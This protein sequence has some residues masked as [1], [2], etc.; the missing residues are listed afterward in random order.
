MI[1]INKL[2]TIG[3][4][5]FIA[6][7]ISQVKY[8]DILISR[9]AQLVS[10]KSM[11]PGII[12]EL[13]PMAEASWIYLTKSKNITITWSIHPNASAP[14]QEISDGNW[15][16]QLFKD[17]QEWSDSSMKV[18][19]YPKFIKHAT[20]FMYNDIY[21]PVFEWH[22]QHKNIAFISSVKIKKSRLRAQIHVELTEDHLEKISSDEAV[23]AIE[24]LLKSKDWISLYN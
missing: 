16:L 22:D 14:L 8:H 17:C 24:E 5:V 18:N 1:T 15:S 6:S 3:I 9:R 4:A 2:L 7:C 11:R 23:A 12:Y 10:A 13:P 20:S 19:G 21:S